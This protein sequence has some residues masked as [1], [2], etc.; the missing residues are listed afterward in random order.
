MRLGE[1]CSN[2]VPSSTTR[3]RE[4]RRRGTRGGARRDQA[5]TPGAN[6]IKIRG[7]IAYITVSARYLIIRTPIQVDGSAGSVET[8]WRDVIG[9]DFAFGE[10]GSLYVTTH[11]AHSLVR[12]DPSGKRTTIAGPDQGMVGS[13]ACTFGTAPG[14]ETALYVCA[15]GGFT[16]PRVGESGYRLLGQR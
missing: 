11:P 10:S 3:S 9:D 6:G 4:R 12:I 2:P 1:V 13:T 14:D 8:I 16:V 7:G 5:C 15:D